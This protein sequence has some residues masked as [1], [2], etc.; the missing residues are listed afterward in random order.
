MREALIN[1]DTQFLQLGNIWKEEKGFADENP[2]QQDHEQSGYGY[3]S[4][5]FLGCSQAPK[6][7]CVSP[8]HIS[9]LLHMERNAEWE[10]S[11]I[12]SLNLHHNSSPSQCQL[13]CTER[14]ESLSD[15]RNMPS[16]PKSSFQHC[17]IRNTV[18]I[19][20]Y[21]M[22]FFLA[23]HWLKTITRSEKNLAE[24]VSHFILS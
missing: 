10:V 13:E 5:S 4:R 19:A 18:T 8:P 14:S 17:R 22:I 23:Q 24:V 16:K 1:C 3:T 21:L 7:P 9:K 2:G 15:Q 11:K 20:S 6:L 12:K